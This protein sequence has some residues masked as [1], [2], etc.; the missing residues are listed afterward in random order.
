MRGFEA[1]NRILIFLAL[2]SG[3]AWGGIRGSAVDAFPVFKLEDHA[4]GPDKQEIPFPQFLKSVAQLLLSRLFYS[5]DRLLSP[6]RIQN[7]CYR[8]PW[9]EW[10][11]R[12]LLALIGQR[13]QG[14]AALTGGDAVHDFISGSP[15][16]A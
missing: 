8:G 9:N 2:Q 6:L 1:S 11:L 13:D 15:E 14:I 7:R 3:F 12:S 16:S 10:G 5:L 4:A